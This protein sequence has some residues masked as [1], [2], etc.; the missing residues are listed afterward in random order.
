MAIKRID[1]FIE[2][3]DQYVMESS[4]RTLRRHRGL[5]QA[6][7]AAALDVSQSQISDVERGRTIS[8]ELA[9][10]IENWSGGLLTAAVLQADR[11][12]NRAERAN[13]AQNA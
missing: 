5:S 13:R 7:L 11:D 9:A 1:D 8:F 4:L 12:R 2:Q 10:K 3:G 6:Q